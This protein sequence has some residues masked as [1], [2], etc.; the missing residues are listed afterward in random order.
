MRLARL[1]SPAL[2]RLQ[3]SVITLVP[4]CRAEGDEQRKKEGDGVQRIC[5]RADSPEAATS[6]RAFAHD[7]IIVTAQ[8]V[9]LRELSVD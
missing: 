6:H 5:R 1:L 8:T 7:Y 3:G 4:T 9:R 2:A